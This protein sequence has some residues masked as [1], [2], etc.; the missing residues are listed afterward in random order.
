MTDRHTTTA[1]SRGQ[2]GFWRGP[3][4]LRR[5]DHDQ[6]RA[7]PQVRD[8]RAPD[9]GAWRSCDQEFL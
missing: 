6:V 3:R 5:A 7:R 4:G 1:K 8:V 2:G 9:L